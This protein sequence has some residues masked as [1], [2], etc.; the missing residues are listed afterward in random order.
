M[1]Y[2][3]DNTE[4]FSPQELALLNAALKIRLE[5]GEEE[6]NASDAINNAWTDNAT[7]ETLTK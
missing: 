7:I 3:Q 5:R 4:G 1:T 2:N 6:K